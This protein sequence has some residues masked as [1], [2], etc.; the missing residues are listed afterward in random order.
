MLNVSIGHY[1]QC[2]FKDSK[3]PHGYN[4]KRRQECGRFA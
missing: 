3:V 2:D 1:L 4:N